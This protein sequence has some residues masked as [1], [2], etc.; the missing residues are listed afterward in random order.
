MVVWGDGLGVL[1]S[2]F[3]IWGVRLRVWGLGFRIWCLGFRLAHDL[4]G[5]EEGGLLVERIPA[6]KRERD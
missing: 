5:A 4:L 3:G 6:E 2:G 1:G